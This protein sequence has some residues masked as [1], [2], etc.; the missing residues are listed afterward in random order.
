MADRL[1]THN[2]HVGSPDYLAQDLA[3]YDAVTAESAGAF[4]AAN[5][6]NS[7]RVVVYAVAGEPDLGKPVPTP[8]AGAVKEGQGVESVNADEAWRNDPPKAG[9]LRPLHLPTPES[10]TLDNGLIVM[11][12]QRAGLPVVAADLVVRT[13]GAANPADKPGLASFTAAML[14]EGTATRNA[15]KIADDL[16]SSA[17]R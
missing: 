15:P 13:G 12:S 5:L 9:P 14:D 8:K 1:N 2:Q 17:P 7:A 11:L 4:A 6:Q 10:V 3:R 16:P